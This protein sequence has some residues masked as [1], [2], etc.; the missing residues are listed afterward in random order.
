MTHYYPLDV[1]ISSHLHI[2]IQSPRRAERFR[3]E[4]FDRGPKIGCLAFLGFHP[5]ALVA[6][7]QRQ[8]CRIDSQLITRSRQ[9]R[10]NWS[11]QWCSP[12]RLE[13]NRDMTE[14]READG[15]ERDR[16]RKM[17]DRGR[18]LREGERG[19]W[20]SV[21]FPHQIVWFQKTERRKARLSQTPT[22]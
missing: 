13:Y 6:P 5:T 9:Y 15:R 12:I 2:W 14:W 11:G 7:E 8:K 16:G 10:R 1:F 3:A 21:L 18:G 20:S 22:T 4:P 17:R 19:G